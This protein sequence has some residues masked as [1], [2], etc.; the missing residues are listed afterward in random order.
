M[1]QTILPVLKDEARLESG[2]PIEVDTS[3]ADEWMRPG[4]TPPRKVRRLDVD[5]V[6]A[7]SLPKALGDPAPET[8][9]LGN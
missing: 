3:T 4:P 8:K 7:R 6:L 2:A 9:A 1:A 5:A